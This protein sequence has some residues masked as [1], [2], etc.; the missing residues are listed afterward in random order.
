MMPFVQPTNTPTHEIKENLQQF[1]FCTLAIGAKYRKL[2]VDLAADL[3]KFSSQPLLILT[4][5]PQDFNQSSQLLVFKHSQ[6][7]VGCYHDK[8]YVIA[9]ALSLYDACVF[10]DADMRILKDVAQIQWQP[11]ISARSCANILQHYQPVEDRPDRIK[12]IEMIKKCSQKFNL[13][14]EQ[15]NFVSE[16]MFAVAKD[17]GKEIKFLELWEKIGNYFELNGIY[18]SEGSVIGLAAAAQEFPLRHQ[19]MPEI[20]FF[21]DKIDAIRIRKAQVDQENCKSIS[22]I[23]NRRHSHSAHSSKKLPAALG[24]SQDISIF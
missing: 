4:D 24:S 18:D 11:G 1:C 9:K 6:Q 10:V 22:R 12:R 15:V 5:K 20:E 2:A 19:E 8:R 7:S 23:I 16:F 14:L 3:E 17:S 21:N 13:D